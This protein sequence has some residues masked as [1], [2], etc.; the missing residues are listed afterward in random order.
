MPATCT[1]AGQDS[2]ATCLVPRC[3]HRSVQALP[4][5]AGRRGFRR[6]EVTMILQPLEPTS[7]EP[8]SANPLWLVSAEN[9]CCILLLLLGL[10]AHI[11]EPV[12]LPTHPGRMCSVYYLS[13]WQLSRMTF[14]NPAPAIRGGIPLSS[15]PRVFVWHLHLQD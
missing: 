7:Q 4:A 10:S 5:E 13:L 9:I 3:L 14:K 11:L 8:K 15:A 2:S 1:Q 12:S 6:P